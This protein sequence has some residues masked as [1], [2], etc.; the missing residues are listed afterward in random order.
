ML[1]TREVALKLLRRQDWTSPLALPRRRPSALSMRRG[2][3]Q[4][5]PAHA[6]VRAKR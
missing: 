6:R 4:A 3:A 5:G 1:L 2:A